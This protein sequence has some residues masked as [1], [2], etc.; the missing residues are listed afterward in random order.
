MQDFCVSM[1]F[2]SLLKQRSVIILE[3]SRI[4][5]CGYFITLKTDI[6]AQRCEIKIIEPIL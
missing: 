6:K 2:W 3:T 5:Y 1:R 4:L